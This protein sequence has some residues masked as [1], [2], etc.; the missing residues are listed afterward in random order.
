MP[1]T[2]IEKQPLLRKARWYSDRNRTYKACRCYLQLIQEDGNSIEAIEELALLYYDRGDYELA[3]ICFKHLLTVSGSRPDVFLRIAYC[4][5]QTGF[6]SQAKR[7]LLDPSIEW[8]DDY[9]EE[10][11]LNLSQCELQLGDP[12][13]ALKFLKKLNI[14]HPSPLYYLLQAEIL[15]SL[16]LFTAAIEICRKGL[17]RDPYFDDLLV[18]KARMH[19]ELREFDRAKKIYLKMIQN[20]LFLGE[21]RYDIEEYL[22]L[23]GSVTEL[24]EILK[25]FDDTLEFI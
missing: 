11:L 2:Q 22:H 4:N 15:E 17:Q 13:Q 14:S 7:I 8:A 5:F 23:N 18:I 19:L 20:Q 12:I 21:A 9:I 16:S 25:Y 1:I 6:Y 10:L 24:E 3:E